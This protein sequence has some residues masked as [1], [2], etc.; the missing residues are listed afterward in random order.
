M[1]VFDTNILITIF[2]FYYIST[3]PSFWG[4]FNEYIENGKIISVR[5]VLMEIEAYHNVNSNLVVWAK[6]HKN[7]FCQPNES[8]MIFVSDIFSIKNFQNN[9]PKKSQLVGRPVADPFVIAKAKVNDGYVVTNEEYKK[10]GAK[11]PNICE[12]FKVNCINLNKFMELEN[13]K[14]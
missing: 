9:I 6:Q 7:I 4:Y 10:N 12:H 13:W 5:D 14:F 11:I 3:F 1:Y 8:E 2:S